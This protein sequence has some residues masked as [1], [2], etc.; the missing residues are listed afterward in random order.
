M[1]TR[2]SADEYTNFFEGETVYQGTDLDSA[3]ATAVVTDWDGNTTKLTVTN[4]VGTISTGTGQTLKGAVSS[5]EYEITSSTTTTL[6]IPN[7]QQDTE[8]TG[9]NEDIE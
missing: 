4:I 3:T 7:D 2:T 9:D 8:P 5:A 6:I 1:G